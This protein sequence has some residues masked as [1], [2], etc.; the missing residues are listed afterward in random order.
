MSWTDGF[1]PTE[2]TITCAG[3]EHRLRWADGVLTA[4]DHDDLDG[5]R[6]LAALGGERCPCAEHLDVW[7]AHRADP[8][9]LVLASRGPG[10]P[11]S[12]QSLEGGSSWGGGGM[13]WFSGGVFDEPEAD[14]V[15]LHDVMLLGAGLPD[16]L[17]AEVVASC[18]AT[19]SVARQAAA[20]HGWITRA[21][22]TWL[23][24]PSATV[25]VTLGPA[26][27]PLA[28]SRAEDGSFAATG[29]LRWIGEVAARGL[30]T[31]WGDLVLDVTPA[32]DGLTLSTIAPDLRATRRLHLAAL[33]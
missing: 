6:T 11:L 23:G 32:T 5:E 33:P 28:L 1:A 9:V 22:R 3:R 4:P 2:A 20:L 21:V 8:A 17:V 14:A 13:V 18:A 12:E 25:A 26:D 27:A 10:D 15:T 31:V 19:A 7:A 24:D 29:S 30:S 16:R